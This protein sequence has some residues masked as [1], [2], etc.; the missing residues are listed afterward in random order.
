MLHQ[1]RWTLKWA[2]EAR[3][4]N[5]RFLKDLMEIVHNT[6]AR[7]LNSVILADSLEVRDV[8]NV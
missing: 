4:Y 8:S 6:S 1:L 3:P 5:E 2:A 7:N